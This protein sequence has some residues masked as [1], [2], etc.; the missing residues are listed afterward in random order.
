MLT[1]LRAKL[2]PNHTAQRIHGPN[3]RTPGRDRRDAC[4]WA[5]RGPRKH[6]RQCAAAPAAG[7]YSEYGVS[8]AAAA[9]AVSRA[10]SGL[11][12]RHPDAAAGAAAGC[13]KRPGAESAGGA[14]VTFTIPTTAACP[15]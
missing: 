13:F 12:I 6:F 15:Q 4:R 8:A 1:G 3:R 7:R 5:G 14:A 10:I 9:G 11:A 2:G